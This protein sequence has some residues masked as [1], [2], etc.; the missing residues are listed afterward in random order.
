MVP[1]PGGEAFVRRWHAPD[2]SPAPILLFHDSLGCVE[3]WR[4]FPAALAQATQRPVLAYDRL[5]FGHSTS[6]EALPGVGFV[7]EEAEQ[8]FPALMQALGVPLCV[9][10]GHSVGGAM[11]LLAAARWPERCQAVVTESAQTY[12]QERTR[13]G[14]RA[15]QAAFAD[16]KEFA[17]LERYHGQRARW[18]LD[19]WTKTWLCPEF[20]D[21]A[22]TADL[23]QVRCPALA[24]HGSA[25]EYGSV[26]F[27]EAIASGVGGR[28]EVEIMADCGHMPHRVEQARVLARIARFLSPLDG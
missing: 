18:V 4:D 20:D 1:V 25:D 9:P 24:I 26:A 17:K 21:W 5:G 12:V 2:E 22:V 3:L 6:R 23:P 19:A 16:A 14:I 11:A 15:A 7:R 13:D 8:I 28:V 27:P 10:F